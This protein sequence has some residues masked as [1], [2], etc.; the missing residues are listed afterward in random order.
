VTVAQLMDGAV[1]DFI[2][3]IQVSFHLMRDDVG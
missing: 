1:L 2:T 3:P